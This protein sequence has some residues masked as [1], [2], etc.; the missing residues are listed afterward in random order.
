MIDL[1]NNVKVRRAGWVAIVLVLLLA[2]GCGS[3]PAAPA[4]MP[5]CKGETCI[6]DVYLEV[7]DGGTLLIQFDLVDRSDGVEFGAEPEFESTFPFALYL[8][9]E[10]GDST[11]LA[12][13]EPSL[14]VWSCYAGND[15]PWSGGSLAAVCSVTLPLS[16]LQ[17]RIEEGDPVR[18][19]TI[20]F[21][22]EFNRE[23]KWLE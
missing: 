2:S 13:M 9:D 5:A 8:D 3:E 11:Y 20:G 6:K 14:D 15:I 22:P 1:D 10:A 4:P 21:Q 19:E 16:T 23:A 17:T 18:I 12:G 7:S